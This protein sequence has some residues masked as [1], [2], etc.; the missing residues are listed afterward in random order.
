MTARAIPKM[1]TAFVRL[2]QD[3]RLA[4]LFSILWL[5]KKKIWCA[6]TFPATSHGCAA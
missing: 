5:H 4:S 3:Y 2:S 1:L 6:S